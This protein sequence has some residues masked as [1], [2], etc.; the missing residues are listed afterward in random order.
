MRIVTILLLVGCNNEPQYVTCAPM[1]AA[2]NDK[3]SIE[4]DAMSALTDQQGTLHVPVMPEAMWRARDR[5]KRD[6][7][8]MTVDP[9]VIVPI[10]RLEHYDLSV[11]WTVTNLDASPGT[12]YVDLNGANE[13]VAYD[14]S[15][16]D[17]DPNDDDEPPAP[18][19]AG[20]IP[21][22]IGPNATIDGVFREDQLV[23][24]A[25]DLEQMSRGGYHPY[26]ANLTISK[27][28]DFFALAN[29]GAEVPREAF[30][31][32]VRVDIVFRP[33]RHMR[34]DFA[35]RVREHVNVI[36]EMGLNAPAGEIMVYDPPDYTYP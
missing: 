19:L 36:H 1:G 17:I 23:E 8:Q 29:G 3:C 26:K 6:E 27:N 25:I 33:D 28:D 20:N 35:L 5:A 10:Y 14:P 11:E 7:I 34:L 18:P 15:I 4:A 31:Q 32:L 30:R 24:A 16:I 21:V 2:P 13:E 9:S 22:D 12:F